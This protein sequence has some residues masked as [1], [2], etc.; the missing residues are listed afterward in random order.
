MIFVS[1]FHFN[2][3]FLSVSILLFF[4][5]VQGASEDLFG[6]LVRLRGSS[7]LFLHMYEYA[8]P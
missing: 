2:W 1:I 8:Y 5:S 6:Y 7:L 4:M 3:P